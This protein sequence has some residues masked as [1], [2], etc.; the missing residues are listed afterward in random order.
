MRNFERRHR[1]KIGP[2]AL[3]AVAALVV[4]AVVLTPTGSA[5]PPPPPTGTYQACLIAGTGNSSCIPTAAGGDYSVLTGANPELQVTIKND[6][7]SSQTLDYANVNVPAGIGVS[8]DTAHSP[9]PASYTTYAST[10]TST[11]LQLRGLGLAP[12]ASQTVAFFVN[13]TSSSCTDGTW[14]TEARSGSTPSAF[15]FPNPP[16]KSGGLT[17]LVAMSCQL[18]F[19]NEPSAALPNKI[20]TSAPYSESGTNVTVVTPASLPVALNGGAVKLGIDS[21]SFDVGT[22]SFTGTGP[23]AFS[24]GSATFP[25]LKATGTGGPFTLHASADGFTN[26]VSSPPFAI[27]KN[28]EACVSTCS[29]LTGT[30]AN[31]NTLTQISTSAGF[32]FLGTSPSSVPSP[33]PLGCQSWTATPGVTGF[34]EFDGR[35]DPAHASMTL[36]YFVPQNA[37]KARYGKNVG[38]QF[39]P[40]CIGVKYVD[41]VTGQPQDCNVTPTPNP[42]TGDALDPNGAFTGATSQ[43]VCGP[44]GYYWGIISS[45]QDKLDQSVNPVVTAWSSPTIGGTTY[46]AFVMSVPAGQDYKGGG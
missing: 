10:S 39:I 24:A 40:I 45:F 7:T 4:F 19:Q 16:S 11:T 1:H 6:N 31:G 35:T 26:A 42:W 43:S 21:G 32:S 30:D 27:T 34:V 23:A 41:P 5:K 13:S 46:R 2:R 37:I 38:Q 20:I 29:T 9:Q 17:T 25:S 22:D 36:T 14:T 44:E 18:T 15:V 8:I 28:G 12:G 3:L 33:T